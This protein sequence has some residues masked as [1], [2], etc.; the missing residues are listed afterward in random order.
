MA[1]RCC[2][3]VSRSDIS[4]G[5]PGPLFA[6]LSF[7]YSGFL[8]SDGHCRAIA[9]QER[10]YPRANQVGHGAGALDHPAASSQQVTGA[11]VVHGFPVQHL[12]VVHV[13]CGGGLQPWHEI[14]LS[15]QLAV[16]QNFEQ[17]VGE[18]GS[19]THGP[20]CG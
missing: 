4:A 13:Q 7:R 11:L 2:P 10:R 5:N 14:V 3:C 15:S 1:A 20:Q 18:S 12:F 17:P 9:E 19:A 8:L 16:M 6:V